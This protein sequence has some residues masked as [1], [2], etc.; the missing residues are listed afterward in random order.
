MKWQIEKSQQLCLTKKWISQ[1][2]RTLE[3]AE[4][5]NSSS[6]CGNPLCKRIEILLENSYVKNFKAA[7]L[8]NCMTKR[9]NTNVTTT[10]VWCQ[11][12]DLVT[13]VKNVDTIFLIE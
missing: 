4:G 1:N 6:Y 8:L 3:T 9:F 7:F 12:I 10:V 5:G 11:I 2:T 13:V